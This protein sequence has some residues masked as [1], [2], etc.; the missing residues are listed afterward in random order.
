M[1]G[2]YG[3]P[4]P[5]RHKRPDRGAPDVKHERWAL[6]AVPRK[7]LGVYIL[8]IQRS[9]RAYPMEPRL[10]NKAQQAP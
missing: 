4:K 6:G 3:I 9:R 1:P 7:G 5:G 10:P 8:S 2:L